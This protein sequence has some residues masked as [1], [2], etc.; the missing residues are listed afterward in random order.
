M[1]CSFR[2]HFSDE[3]SLDG[4]DVLSNGGSEVI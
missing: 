2:I 3:N 1:G 4:W